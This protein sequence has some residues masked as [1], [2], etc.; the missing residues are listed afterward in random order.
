MDR[1]ARETFLSAPKIPPVYRYSI[2]YFFSLNA[3]HEGLNIEEAVL[4]RKVH[5]PSF[6]KMVP[7]FEQ[8]ASTTFYVLSENDPAGARRNL[9]ATA[10]ARAIGE[11]VDRPSQD[12]VRERMEIATNLLTELSDSDPD[13]TEPISPEYFRRKSEERTLEGREWCEVLSDLLGYIHENEITTWEAERLAE[14]V[15]PLYL[16]RVLSY[17]DEIEGADPDEVER[18]IETERDIL[19]EL[20]SG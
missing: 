10:D 1:K 4:G 19:R 9:D 7:M 12:S 3:V 18:S 16:L 5:A 13:R 8:I 20:V 11:F 14:V 2:D 17:F 15:T 6:G